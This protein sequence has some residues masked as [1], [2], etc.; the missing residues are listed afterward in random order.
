MDFSDQFLFFFSALGVFNSLILSGYFFFKK[1][2]TNSNLFLGFLLLMLT[3]RI[4]KSVIFYFDD[5]TSFNFLQVGIS[6]CL[7]IGPSLFFYVLSVTHPGSKVVKQWKAHFL[8]LLIGIITFGLIYPWTAYPM[9]WFV[10][11]IYW[12]YWIW[13]AYSI[14][15]GVVIRDSFT[16]IFSKTEKFAGFDF[17]LICIFI[18]NLS[19]WAAFK[20]VNFIS[21]IAGALTFTFVLFLMVVLLFFNKRKISIFSRNPKYSNKQIEEGEA[22]ELS[23]QLDTLMKSE[24]LFKDANLKLQ[25]VASKLRIL[26]HRLSQLLNDNLDQSFTSY[27]NA[28]RIELSK[29][30]IQ[31]DHHLSL[32]SIGYACGFNSKS[33]FY[34]AFKKQT[35]T[36]PAQFKERF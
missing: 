20:F 7:M 30:M 16:R 18:G 10:D 5:E 9:L 33:T 25:D 23:K 26:P 3:I 14:G 31:K 19:I 15:S 27:V 21:Y 29:E 11:V 32:E 28:F 6:A 1:P 24:E 17:W 36:T 22:K 2:R 4:G 8:I 34:S 35:G 12:V 13:L